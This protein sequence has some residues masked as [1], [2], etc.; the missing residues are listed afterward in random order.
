MTFG[1]GLDSICWGVRLG[2]VLPQLAPEE[3]VGCTALLPEPVCPEATHS[4][5]LHNVL[6]GVAWTPRPPGCCFAQALVPLCWRGVTAA[7]QCPRD[8]EWPLPSTTHTDVHSGHPEADPVI[9]G[10][11][12]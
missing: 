1:G 2:V 10:R 8:E 6:G 5:C 4:H 11:R 12:G 9:E 3:P 7:P